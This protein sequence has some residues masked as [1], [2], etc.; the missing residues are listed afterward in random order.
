[1]VV[2]LVPG[3]SR[4]VPLP[5][6]ASEIADPIVGRTAILVGIAPDVL[7]S[8]WVGARRTTLDEPRVQNGRM[9]WHEVQQNPEPF[10]VSH[11]K[12]MVEIG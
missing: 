6:R 1:M 7:I 2:I 5:G 9:V 10:G 8:F 12:K 3:A 4:S 11:G